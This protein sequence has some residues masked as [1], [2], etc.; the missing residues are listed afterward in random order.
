MKNR[1]TDGVAELKAFR[2]I[3]LLVTSMMF[4]MSYFMLLLTFFVAYLSPSKLVIV[5]IN[6]VG[7]ANIEFLFL[8]LTIPCV[9]YYLRSFAWNREERK[10]WFGK[11]G[12]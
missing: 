6:S 1:K 5:N 9:V 3:I 4:V 7:E 12:E 8:L 2:F 10:I 11:R